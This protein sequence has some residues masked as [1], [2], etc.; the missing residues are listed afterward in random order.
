MILVRGIKKKGAENPLYLRF[1]PQ[2]RGFPSVVGE[3]WAWILKEQ[4]KYIKTYTIFLVV[5]KHTKKKFATLKMIF[6]VFLTFG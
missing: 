6:Y 2:L 3:F 4:E 5:S 1:D